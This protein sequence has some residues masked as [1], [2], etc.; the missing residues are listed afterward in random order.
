LHLYIEFHL[1][2]SKQNLLV[3]LLSHIFEKKLLSHNISK[4]LS[5][6]RTILNISHGFCLPFSFS[7]VGR[8][9]T[10]KIITNALVSL[11]LSLGSQRFLLTPSHLSAPLDWDRR[12][13]V[14]R[15]ADRPFPL[16]H[17]VAHNAYS[18]PTSQRLAPLVLYYYQSQ[19][20]QEALVD[21]TGKTP[22][23]IARSFAMNCKVHPQIA[24][25]M[26]K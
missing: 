10:V 24:G 9:V 7:V 5:L 12:L 19:A 20:A 15:F 17:P 8:I 11:T 2:L 18:S 6:S 13:L 21:P 4:I 25:N 3:N 22:M 14:S 1:C 23:D 16:M 26:L